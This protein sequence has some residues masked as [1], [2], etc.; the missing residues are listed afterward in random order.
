MEWPFQSVANLESAYR[1]RKEFL[2]SLFYSLFVFMIK[3]QLINNW[4]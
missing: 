3:L 4:F 2:S 1:T